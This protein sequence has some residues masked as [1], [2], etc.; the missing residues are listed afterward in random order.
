MGH[1]GNSY[2]T[3]NLEFMSQFANII[4]LDEFTKQPVSEI[5]WGTIIIIMQKSNSHSEMLYYI[6]E[7]YKNGWSRSVVI[8][9]I[10]DEFTY[11]EITPQFVA[12]FIMGSK[13]I[14]RLSQ[15]LKEYVKGYSYD[16]LKWMS[17]FAS[18][19]S[20][21]EIRAQP[22]PLIPWSFTTNE[23]SAQPARQIPW[24]TIVLIMQ[25][26]YS[27]EEMLYYINETYKKME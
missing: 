5:P 25:K 19:F 27:H 12:Q 8:I 15:D 2:S 1:F 23:I 17:Q 3:R 20:K 10:T 18:I 16:Q 14:E 21:E 9:R 13:Y 11:D 4:S 22:V 24:F 6:N 26:S 7:T